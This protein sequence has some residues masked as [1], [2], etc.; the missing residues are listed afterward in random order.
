[1][2]RSQARELTQTSFFNGLA[3]ARVLPRPPTAL[4]LSL[5][6]RELVTVVAKRR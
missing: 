4:N 1:M 5:P 2:K 3:W 6:S